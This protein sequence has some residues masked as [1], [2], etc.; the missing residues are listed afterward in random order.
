M[1]RLSGYSDENPLGKLS[2]LVRRFVTNLRLL[3]RRVTR[4]RHRQ[5]KVLILG[6]GASKRAGYPVAADLM[7]T[8]E[9]DAKGSGNATLLE[10][11]QHWEDTKNKAPGALRLL[12]DDPNP[13]VILS[14][15]DLCRMSH[16]AQVEQAIRPERREE[17]VSRGLSD[18]TIPDDYFTSPDQKWLY[19]ADTARYRLLDCLIAYFEWKHYEDWGAPAA[20]REYLRRELAQLRPGDVVITTNWDTNCE[21]TLFEMGLWNPRDG[22]GFVRDLRG[23]FN[24]PVTGRFAKPSEISVLKLHGSVGW[25]RSG[26]EVYFT[27]EFLQRFA[28]PEEQ[29]VCDPVAL[30]RGTRPYYDPVIAYPSFLK[31][32]G[33]SAILKIWEQADAALRQ[34]D[35][36]EVWGY[37]LP[38]SDIAMRVLLNPLRD[39]LAQHQARVSVHVPFDDI[40]ARKTRA[41]WR[42]FLPGAHVDKKELG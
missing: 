18:A 32:L 1:T 19:D 15:F 11:W 10:A 8:I 5:I 24:Q 36:I 13:E 2:L 38:E 30:S 40:P 23:D 27:N 42:A 17:V 22:C 39:R 35:E 9:A 26:D 34:A 16:F 3:F 29:G 12:L 28:P 7:S 25:Y 4:R 20:R 41:R 14:V 33:A 31:K 6:A 21:R 37:S